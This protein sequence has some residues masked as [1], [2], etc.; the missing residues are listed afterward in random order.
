M[1]YMELII[2]IS[3]YLKFFRILQQIN[4]LPLICPSLLKRALD[5]TVRVPLN[6]SNNQSM[7]LPS[8]TNNEKATVITESHHILP[9]NTAPPSLTRAIA[10]IQN[11]SSSPSLSW[12]GVQ[13]VLCYRR[14][15]HAPNKLLFTYRVWHVCHRPLGRWW[16][17]SV[18]SVAT[19]SCS[20]LRN[21]N[22]NQL[23]A[24]GV[25]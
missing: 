13:L 18:Q 25:P 5:W 10:H 3:I 8:Q 9:P 6:P 20:T 14:L 16:R 19:G 24:A 23:Q 4:S 1:F 2:P 7:A 15:R 17:Q 22:E 21:G 12:N 11:I